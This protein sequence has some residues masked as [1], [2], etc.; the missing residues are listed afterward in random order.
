MNISSNTIRDINLSPDKFTLN[1]LKSRLQPI[2]ERAK[3]ICDA[4][5]SLINILKETGPETLAAYGDDDQQLISCVN[6]ITNAATYDRD[7]LVISKPDDHPVITSEL[8]DEERQKIRFYARTSLKSVSG[9]PVGYL[10]VSDASSR[11]LSD[12]QQKQLQILGDGARALLELYDQSNRLSKKNEKLNL[13]SLLLKNSAD[14]TFIIEQD[15]GRI[16]DVNSGIENELG[17][18]PGDLKGK[19]FADIIQSNPFEG[20]SVDEWMSSMEKNRGRYVKPL[21]LIDYQQNASWFQCNF[22]T[23]DG[24]WFV[25]ASDISEKKEAEQGVLE[26]KEKFKK[27]VEVST[28]L[29]Y[30][31][32][33]N[34]GDL[35][36]GDELTAV[37]GYPHTDRFVN[38]DWWIDKIHP[39]DLDRVIHDVAETLDGESEKMKLVYRIRT[40]EGSYKYVMNNNYVDRDEEGKPQHIIGAIVDISE[41]VETEERSQRHKQLLKNVADNAWSA[42]WIRDDSGTFMF[43]NEAFKTLYELE[44]EQVTDS[45]AD[46]FFDED[47]ASEMKSIDKEVLESGDRVEFEKEFKVDG[48]VKHYK[49]SLFPM[50]GVQGVGDIVGGMAMDISSEKESQKKLEQSLEEKETLLME[51]HHRVKNNL[52]VVSGMMQLQAFKEQEEQIQEKLFASTGRIKTMA[53]IHELLYKSASFT[54]LKFDENIEKLV[55]EITGTFQVSVELDI[56]YDL[57]PVEL[58]INQAIPGSLIVNEVITNVLK[59]AYDDGD[60]GKLEVT[61]RENNN[62][63]SLTIQDDGKGLPENFDKHQ[64]GGSLGLELIETLVSQLKGEYNYR[65]LDNG[66]EFRVTFEKVKVRGSGSYIN[67]GSAG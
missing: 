66:T 28:D 50:Y 55:T 58:N 46:D 59:H 17:Y 22:T 3:A 33:W 29:I 63:I 32:E 53:T 67:R 64:H 18:Q 42:T 45:K 52:A 31:L 15:S 20:Y 4:K 57:D 8:S 6:R 37:L 25:T 35:A 5:M 40:Y 9:N 48:D 12:D 43:A 38:Y 36:W 16:M 30:E 65:S 44:G 2:L 56:T 41:L 21:Q 54:D 62:D 34:S 13:Y 61:L 11:D 19:L 1:E 26:L 10:C 27:V 23:E 60:S 39:E 14:I 49:F 7:I 47:T 24:R 51:I